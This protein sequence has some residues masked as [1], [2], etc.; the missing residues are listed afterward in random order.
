M[1]GSL[2]ALVSVCSNDRLSASVNPAV[3]QHSLAASKS[4]VL[5]AILLGARQIN[6][7]AAH[8]QV[9]REHNWFVPL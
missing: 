1:S 4:E 8:I 5:V 6:V 9:A 3:L 2:V 7:V